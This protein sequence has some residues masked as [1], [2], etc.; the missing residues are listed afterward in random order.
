LPHGDAALEQKAADLI[1]QTRA[2]PDQARA[3]TV[4]GL[5]TGHE[6]ARADAA[7]ITAKKAYAEF[8]KSKTFW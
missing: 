4:H 2:L 7:M 1:G 3:H 5:L 6:D 8:A